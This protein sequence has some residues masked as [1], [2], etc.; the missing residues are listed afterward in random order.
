MRSYA[1][2]PTVRHQRGFSLLELMIAVVVVG[3]LASLAYPSFI[4]AIRKSRRAEAYNALS[5]VQQAQERWRA[6]NA[7]YASTLT[8]L[9]LPSTTP[10]GY[11]TIALS[12]TSATEYTATATAVS[13]TTQAGDQQCGKLGVHMGRN[14]ASS[15]SSNLWYAGAAPAGTLTYATTSPCWSR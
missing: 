14:G 15:G 5:A 13:G 2:N 10:G 4:G 12:G 6:N 1:P 3:I 8:S 7:S 11:Y 9:N